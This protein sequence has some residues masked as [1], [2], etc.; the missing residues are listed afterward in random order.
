MISE[1]QASYLSYSMNSVLKILVCQLEAMKLSH[2]FQT[3]LISSYE[4]LELVESLKSL[5]PKP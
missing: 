3:S 5:F 4:C 2:K 1:A